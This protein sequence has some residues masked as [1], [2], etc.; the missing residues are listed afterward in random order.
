MSKNGLPVHAD[1]LRAMGEDLESLL[2]QLNPTKA[3]ELMYN[4]PFWAREQQIAP[5]GNWNTWY[6][7]AGRGFGKTRAGVEWVLR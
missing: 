6:V 1:D 4:W 2:L 3:E 5:E 7:N